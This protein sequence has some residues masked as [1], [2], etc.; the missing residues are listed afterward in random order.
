MKPTSWFPL[1]ALDVLLYQVEATKRWWGSP[2]FR[3]TKRPFS[4]EEVVSLRGTLPETYASDIQAC[5]IPPPIRRRLLCLAS[6]LNLDKSHNFRSWR[7]CI[8]LLFGYFMVSSACR[9]S[10]MSVGVFR[11][12]K[13]I[14][15]SRFTFS[16]QTHTQNDKAA[17]RIPDL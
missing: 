2:R 1:F 10:R 15:V 5:I 16:L 14:R 3:F 12:G 4:A 6:T 17:P 9:C 8:R 13:G 7:C 11:N